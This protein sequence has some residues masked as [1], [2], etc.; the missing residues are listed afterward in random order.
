MTDKFLA[1]QFFL[2]WSFFVPNLVSHQFETALDELMKVD[3]R[4]FECLTPRELSHVHHQFVQVLDPTLH[5]LNR[6]QSFIIVDTIAQHRYAKA[7]AAKR[8][9]DFVRHLSRRLAHC[10]KRLLT[11]R[12]TLRFCRL[13]HVD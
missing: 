6:V 11:P 10:R 2:D 7:Y 12:T 3:V 9:S 1:R 5:Q 8:I 4:L 13:S